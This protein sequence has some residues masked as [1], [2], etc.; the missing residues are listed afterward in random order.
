MAALVAYP[1]HRKHASKV[2]EAF[3]PVTDALEECLSSSRM[4]EDPPSPPRNNQLHEESRPLRI[5]QQGHGRNPDAREMPPQKNAGRGIVNGGV[6]GSL[7]SK[8]SRCTS[9]L[10]LFP[11]LSTSSVLF[12]KVAPRDQRPK[13]M[14]ALQVKSPLKSLAAYP[15]KRNCT[16]ETSKVATVVLRPCL[17]WSRNPRRRR[18]SP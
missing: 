18:H 14:T 11:A 15:S 7:I 2:K 13:G 5:H 16:R 4:W 9:V 6:L 3:L 10:L 8:Q 1:Q 12:Y 17:L